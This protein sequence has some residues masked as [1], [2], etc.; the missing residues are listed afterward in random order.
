MTE[1][2]V[3]K[4]LT[5]ADTDGSGSIDFAEWKA[6][7]SKL[8]NEKLQTAFK[9][10]DKD[11]SGSISINEIKNALG[12][13]GNGPFDDQLWSDLIKEVDKDDSGSIDFEEFKQMMNC[14]TDQ[15]DR[16][17]QRKTLLTKKVSF[18]SSKGEKDTNN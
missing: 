13:T 9:F 3:D 15:V 17:S 6:A 2:E 8:T 11:G 16:F 18:I 7:T 4:I 14:L 12:V 10:F 1:Q 5:A